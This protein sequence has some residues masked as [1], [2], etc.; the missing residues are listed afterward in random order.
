ML[1]K[2]CKCAIGKHYCGENGYFRDYGMILVTGGA[3]FIGANFVLD[4]LAQSDDAVINLD[5]LTYAGNRENLA[6][7][8]GDERHLFVQGVIG[9]PTL[10]ANL[11]AQHQPRA[12]INFTAESDVDRAIH[13]PNFIQTNIVGSYHNWVGKQ[14]ADAVAK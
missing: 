3:G 14:C 5:V 13:G 1:S 4:W 10:A 2:K 9:N 8:F 11:L 12:V 7:L 6:S